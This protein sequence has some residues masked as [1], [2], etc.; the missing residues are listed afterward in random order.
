MKYSWGVS[1]KKRNYIV[2]WLVLLMLFS[3]NF[4]EFIPITRIIGQNGPFA[5]Y[6]LSLF[7]AFTFNRRAWIRDSL[8]WLKP[9]WWILAG[10]FLSFFP[11]YLYY[12]QS[13]VQ[14]F[15]TYRRMLEFSAFP[16]LIAL[17]P[18][19][20]ELRHSLQYFS[21]IFLL[22]SLFVTFVAPDW[23]KVEE[24][25]PL[26]I[27]DDYLVNIPGIRLVFLGFVLSL[28][29]LIKE[30]RAGTV[31]W[32]LFEFGIL[33]LAQNRTS[34][35]A[36]FVVIGLV[37]Y[38]MRMGTNKLILM[39]II[40]LAFLFLLVF[41]ANQW[42]LL[43][44]ETMD[45]IVN[46]EY[47]RNKALAYI[48]LPREPLR[49][50][51]GDGFISLNVNPLMTNLQQSGIF[52]SD[53]GLAGM[54]HQFGVIPVLTILVM[55]FRGLSRKKSFIVRSSAIY[56]LVGILTL[57]YFALGES[58]LWLSIYLYMYYIDGS[59]SYVEQPRMRRTYTWGQVKYRSIVS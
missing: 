17:R 5:F 31:I 19:E 44:Q 13:F 54:W 59:P 39:V 36:F 22:A 56:V 46:P 18:T 42:D 40:G 28:G 23:V 2:M 48:A 49:Y 3:V 29:K 41:T 26:I 30:N 25:A 32:T 45:Q 34:L 21:V 6:M 50:V 53:I 47:N 1:Q 11:A 20:R 9:L 8:E 51:L 16:I 57:S 15:F 43:Y 58:M 24:G 35:L 52:H 10:I 12:G 27:G 38:T 4:F 14:S 55:T 7:F 33:Y 37:I